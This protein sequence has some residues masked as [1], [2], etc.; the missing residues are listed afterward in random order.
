MVTTSQESTASKATQFGL[1]LVT[2]EGIKLPAANQQIEYKSD[3]NT[4]MPAKIQHSSGMYR[5]PLISSLP[6][7]GSLFD[8]KEGKCT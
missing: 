5:L 7:S 8:P 2:T 1:L 3:T 4:L 6:W